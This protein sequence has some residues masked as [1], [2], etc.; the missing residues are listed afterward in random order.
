M[1]RI[2]ILQIGKTKD[3]ELQI[4]LDEYVLRMRRSMDVQ[5]ITVK[6]E[7]ELWQRLVPGAYTIALEVKGKAMTSES[8]SDFLAKLAVQGHSHIQFL[9]GPADG[10]A[11]YAVK[12]DLL[13]SLSTMT[14]S[15]QT[16]RLLLFEQLYRVCTLWEGKPFAK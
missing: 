14:F 4:L 6:K 1:M 11:A 9:I 10:F 13:L 8:F 2:S 12:P 16:I 5:V 15:H 7:A 3:A